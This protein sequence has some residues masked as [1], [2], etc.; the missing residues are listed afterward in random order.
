MNV[1]LLGVNS[2]PKNTMKK[3]L[4]VA[5]SA[6]LAHLAIGQQP[7]QA[8]C[9]TNCVINCTN[10][11]RVLIVGSTNYGSIETY[12]NASGM[13]LVSGG[14]IFG[15]DSSGTVLTFT[16][17]G[18]NPN[19]VV[20]AT[21]SYDC[22][23][24]GCSGQEGGGCDYT[25]KSFTITMPPQCGYLAVRIYSRYGCCTLTYCEL[26]RNHCDLPGNGE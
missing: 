18:C 22:S 26:Y 17:V 21:I 9:I 25:T 7:P 15:C 6:L 19:P 24:I 12:T 3:T 13:D 5:A 10:D 8:P 1:K 4:L 23:G 14:G 20:V 16:T 2:K 11:A